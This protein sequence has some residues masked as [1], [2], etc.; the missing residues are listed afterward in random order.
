ME[1]QP[2]PE[3]QQEGAAGA[4]AEPD[5]ES[6]RPQE[7][8]E[9]CRRVGLSPEGLKEE[10]VRRLRAAARPPGAVADGT[11]ADGTVAE[12][13]QAE[14]TLDMV[15]PDTEAERQ[16]LEAAIVRDLAARMGVD[17]KRINVTGIAPA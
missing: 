9:E 6:M 11:V 13:V 2:E 1:P 3:P 5:Y 4:E 7:L 17:P 10:L 16:A 12:G 15:A 14:L 8:K